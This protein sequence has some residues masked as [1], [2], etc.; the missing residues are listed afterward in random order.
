M[1]KLRNTIAVFIILCGI[2]SMAQQ[3][4][5]ASAYRYEDEA[6]HLYRLGLF[7]GRS[8]DKFDPDLGAMLDRQTGVTLFLNFFGKTSEVNKLSSSEIERILSR[9]TDNGDILPWAR[10]YMAYAVKTGMIVGTSSYTLSPEQPLNGLASAAMILRQL[11]FSVVEKDYFD[12]VRIFCNRTG[13]GQSSIDYFNRPRL[14]KDDA[15]GMLYAALF[16][17]CASGN[18]LIC[19]FISSGIVSAETALTLKLVKYED[20]GVISSPEGGYIPPERPAGYQQAYFQIYDALINGIDRIWL[21]QNEYTD[22]FG[23]VKE[24]ITVCN[25]E[26]PEILYYSG[27]VYRTDG[28]LTLKYSKDR[29]TIL[30]HRSELDKKIREILS[31]IIRPGM[32]AYQKEKAVH[33][34]L[35]SKCEYDIEGYNKNNI[36]PESYTAY[37]ALCLGKAVCI[38][39]SEA[40]YLLL[41]R[42]GVETMIIT[43]ESKGDPHAWNLVKLDG[44]FYHLDITWN[45]TIKNEDDQNIRYYYF[46]L[47]D[48][49]ISRDH[50]WDR[51]DYP[52]CTSK[53]YEYYTYNNLVVKNQ[54]EF[55]DRVVEEVRNGNR[56]ITLKI[57]DT[58]MFN[59]DNATEE[60]VGNLCLGC[61]YIYNDF[62]GVAIMKF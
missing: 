47:D 61:R 28:L 26:N 8:E 25:T 51:A 44:Q 52:A 40:A 2:L 30:K 32:T 13:L 37:G 5:A 56:S 15:I 24:I 14:I 50:T 34:Y 35:V 43:G 42:A 59:I 4:A 60:I 17:D 58:G 12:S 22:T 41:N 18:S 23:K 46:N 57:L 33:D 10:K 3:A 19:D 7:A 54:H 62:H 6:W 29:Q 27:L 53:K 55:I 38:G 49:A 20:L 21:I 16:A 1:K 36:S 45:D 39:Y 31:E 9:Y 11:G 48:T